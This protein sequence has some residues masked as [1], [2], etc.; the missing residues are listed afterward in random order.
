MERG[1]GDDG[2][3]LGHDARSVSGTVCCFR[4]TPM[5]SDDAMT[6]AAP[7]ADAPERE[8]RRPK[9]SPRKRLVFIVLTMLLPIGVLAAL[10]GSLRLAGLGGYTP[11]FSTVGTFDDGSTLVFT[12]KM[13]PVSYY[14]S[15][16]SEGMTLDPIAFVMPKPPGTI[17]VMWIGA[18]AAKGI[19]QPRALRASAFLE[20]MLS[21]LWPESTV[22]VLNVGVT[23]VAA[24]PVLGIMTESL[25]YQPDLVVVYLGNNEFYGAY[26]VASLHTAGRSPTMIRLIRA[27][28]STAI[29]QGFDRLV[30]GKVVREPGS[31]ME[32]MVGQSNIGADDPTRAEASHNLETFVGQMIDRCRARGVPIVVCTP[33]A[34]ESDMAPI[35]LDDLSTLSPDK[36]VEAE[37]VLGAAASLMHADPKAAEAALRGVL[38]IAPEHATAHHLLGR[39]LRAQE[40]FDEAAESFR[41]AIDLDPMPWRPPAS[42]VAGIRRAATSR[43]APLAD[44]ETVFRA[45]SPIGSPGWDLLDD[46]VHPSLRGQELAARTVVRAMT[47][48]NGPMAPDTS[49]VEA[50][51]DWETYA[52]RLGRNP[53]D[54][55]G[56]AHAMRMLGSISF[57]KR[58]NPE[59][60]AQSTMTCERIVSAQHPIVVEKMRRWADPASN[61][62]DR[63]PITGLV[64]DAK[65]KLGEAQE[66]EFLFRVAATNSTPFGSRRLAFVY[67]SLLAA[68]QARV[69]NETDLAWAGEAIEQGRFLVRTDQSPSGQAER[70][71]GQLLQLQGEFEKSIEYLEAARPKVTGGHVLATDQAL[72]LAYLRTGRLDRARAVI[73]AGLSSP[74]AAAYRGMMGL[75]Q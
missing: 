63:F 29:A 34:N 66:A 28:R 44:L 57:F 62:V 25:R 3:A 14:F 61:M 15:S 58:S 70:F 1:A 22:E 37:H 59:L 24:F 19:P 46:H 5:T 56:V 47:S 40:R 48:L 74:N 53:F 12:D 6:K 36:R 23:G 67:F 31:L 26:G 68:Q 51:P 35:G 21:D 60:L 65:L 32:A 72:V 41:R 71:T 4:V 13:G 10:E 38:D 73:E 7:D 64:A 30:H 52:T 54:E 43:N 39:A 55:F 11:T 69:L 2:V 45:E 27:T 33:P 42:S 9:L 8:Q 75:L 16:R 18:S 49:A 50:L 20:A 17:R